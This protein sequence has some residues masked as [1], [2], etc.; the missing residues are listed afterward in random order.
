MSS[1]VPE[2]LALLHHA[3]ELRAG[4]TTWEA[5]ATELKVPDAELR[6]LRAANAR[7]YDRLA[8]RAEQEFERETVRATL[9]RLRELMKSASEGIAMMAAGTV[10]R[11][12]LAR[13]RDDQ[14]KQRERNRCIDDGPRW[15][16]ELPP[17]PSRPVTSSRQD[18]D[19]GVTAGVTG[20]CDTP[21]SRPEPPANQGVT[22]SAPAR[23]SVLCDNVPTPR[24]PAGTAPQSVPAVGG[25]NSVSTGPAKGNTMLVD[26]IRRKKWLPNGLAAR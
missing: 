10:I 22:S 24:T 23:K 7:L 5:V 25:S 14:R 17:P 4:G 2:Q 21:L 19:R 16:N 13:M 26:A 9:A 6:A 20:G 12:Q 3:A 8:R 1:L 11:Y 15:R 18:H